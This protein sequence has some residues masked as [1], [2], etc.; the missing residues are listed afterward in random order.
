MQIGP[1]PPARYERERRPIR[2]Y[3]DEHVP[4]SVVAGLRQRGADV[5]TV[6][7]AGMMGASDAEH[8]ARATEEGRT[9]YTNDDDFLR[10]ARSEAHAGVAFARQ[11]ISIGDAIRKLMRLRE[12]KT[13]DEMRNHVVYL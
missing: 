9:V 6:K 7:E 1:R 4:T 3:T 12:R 11:G 8:L 5:L 13:T 10:L 2:F